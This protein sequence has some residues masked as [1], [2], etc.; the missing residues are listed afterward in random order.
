MTDTAYLLTAALALLVLFA[1]HDCAR[2]AGRRREDGGEQPDEAPR[3]RPSAES[4]EWAGSL[5]DVI[6]REQRLVER[7]QVEAERLAQTTDHLTRVLFERRARRFAHDVW[8]PW[9][10]R[11]HFAR[12][13]DGLWACEASSD[14]R[15]VYGP[16]G[17]HPSARSA[18]LA[19]TVGAMRHHHAE[20]RA[21]TGEQTLPHGPNERARS[22]PSD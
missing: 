21:R 9:G 11:A 22:H 2:R 17:P 1:A 13:S 10:C 4:D 18:A 8:M 6:E 12:G 3:P 14:G 7:A 15:T 20:L 5:L 19:A 16:T